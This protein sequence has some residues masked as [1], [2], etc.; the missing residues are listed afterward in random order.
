MEQFRINLTSTTNREVYETVE[1]STYAEVERILLEEYGGNAEIHSII[2]L[3]EEG[4]KLYEN[5]WKEEE[6]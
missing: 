2:K 6:I 5:Y 1:A 3:D 4:K